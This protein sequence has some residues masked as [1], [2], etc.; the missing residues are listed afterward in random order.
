M[1]LGSSVSPSILGC[2]V[3][4]SVV[5]S[6]R[7]HSCV[8]YSAGSGASSVHAVMSVLRNSPLSLVHLSTSCR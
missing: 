5:L 2:V 7:S 1:S 4:G 3:M 8:L 6:I